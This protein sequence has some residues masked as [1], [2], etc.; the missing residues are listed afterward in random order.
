M[1]SRVS[2]RPSII[3]ST[4]AWD[5]TETLRRTSFCRK[6]WLGCQG[7]VR[8]NDCLWPIRR[9][10]WDLPKPRL[11]TA[12]LASYKRSSWHAARYR[13]PTGSC[14]IR[15]CAHHSNGARH[16]DRVHPSLLSLGVLVVQRIS[17][18]QHDGCA[19][20]SRDWR[21]AACLADEAPEDLS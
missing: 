7:P 21:R 10:R 15:T 17:T 3:D 13:R 4:P 19:D 14:V 20:L 18:R 11:A 16:E 2:P 8:I 5:V 12:L 9:D 1:S 6:R